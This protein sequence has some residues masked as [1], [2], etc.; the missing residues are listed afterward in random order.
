[1]DMVCCLAAVLFKK[2]QPFFESMMCSSTDRRKPRRAINFQDFIGKGT[3]T[4]IF[5]SISSCRG[6]VWNYASP[7]YWISGDAAR[8]A[9]VDCI[10]GLCA[11]HDRRRLLP[12]YR[13]MNTY[14]VARLAF[15]VSLE[16]VAVQQ[17]LSLAYAS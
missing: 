12:L 14:E 13:V 3:Q 4:G 2:L 11:S 8:N 6:R 16:Y 15:E 5:A 9:I 17:R 7:W 10:N 1:M